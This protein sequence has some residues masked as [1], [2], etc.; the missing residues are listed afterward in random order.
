MRTLC[1]CTR[2]EREANPA[3]AQALAYHAYRRRTPED[4]A[5]PLALRWQQGAVARG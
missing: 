2:A 3:P 4:H 5:R 1:L